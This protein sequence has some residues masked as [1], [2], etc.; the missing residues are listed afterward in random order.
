MH[1][2]VARRF[3]KVGKIPSALITDLELLEGYPNLQSVNV[4]KN[5]LTSLRSLERVPYL[6]TLDAEYGELSAM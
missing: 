3:T 1:R 4:S 2:L 6:T 5:L